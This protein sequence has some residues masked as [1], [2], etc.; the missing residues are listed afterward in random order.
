V[1]SIAAGA[2]HSLAIHQDG[3]AYAWGNGGDGQ[4]C[5]FGYGSGSFSPI[6][7]QMPNIVRGVSAA[8]G[9]NH[10]MVLDANG[11][12]W[13]CGD[14]AYGQLG[15][16]TTADS[17]EPVTVAILADALRI[18]AGG[19]TSMA[20]RTDGTVYTWGRNDF[21]QLGDGTMTNR[22][23]ITSVPGFSNAAA[24]AVGTWHTLAAK[25]NASAY[26]WGRNHSGQVG[27]GTLTNR[28][29]P[30]MSLLP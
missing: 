27:D 17:S 4:L 11:T 12:V 21:G 8:A 20:L 14:N 13:A 15:N 6:I 23:T 28:L 19:H 1:V 26:V 9:A 25:T 29:S 5:D 10:T 2:S 24:I 3:S 30:T 22:T 16:G 18:A 7:S